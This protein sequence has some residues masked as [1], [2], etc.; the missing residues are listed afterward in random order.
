MM[1]ITADGNDWRCRG[2]ERWNI[3]GA[4]AVPHWIGTGAEKRFIKTPVCRYW[5]LHFW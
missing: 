3:G 4:T 1:L 2:T 5:A